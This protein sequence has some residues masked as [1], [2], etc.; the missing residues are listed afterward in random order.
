HSAVTTTSAS[1]ARRGLRRSQPSARRMHRSSDEMS[2]TPASSSD[3]QG[4]GALLSASPATARCSLFPRLERR[5]PVAAA[6]R[7]RDGPI[8]STLTPVG[9]D[10]PWVLE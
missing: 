3:R 6:P 9:G 8:P 2:L 5:E 7:L 4:R 10:P 1:P